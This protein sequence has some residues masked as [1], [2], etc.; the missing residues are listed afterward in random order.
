MTKLLFNPSDTGV[1]NSII[2]ALGGDSL[3]WY[4]DTK[5]ALFTLMIV[6]S[7]LGFST[8]MMIYYVALLGVPQTYVEAARSTKMLGASVR[9]EFIF[10][11]Y[12]TK[13]LSYNAFFALFQRENPTMT[14]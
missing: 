5:I 14:Q 10:S 9:Y 4:N 6:P 1:I 12:L 13:S 2:I 3:G 8:Q 7:L 11:T